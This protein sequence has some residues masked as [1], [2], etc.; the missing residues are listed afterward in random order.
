MADS[1]TA[2]GVREGA[3]TFPALVADVAW[4]DWRQARRALLT[5]RTNESI[6]SVNPGSLAHGESRAAL[7]EAEAFERFA[8]S[9][10]ERAQTAMQYRTV[11]P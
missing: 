3:E 4:D 5:A 8:Y 9:R 11:L 7:E 1:T 2:Q 6:A 10:W